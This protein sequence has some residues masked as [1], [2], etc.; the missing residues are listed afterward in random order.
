M[1]IYAKALQELDAH[2]HEVWMIGD[3]LE[4]EVLVPQQLG[5][6][7]VWVDYRGSGLPRQHAAWPFRVIRTFSDILTLL[8]REFPE[9][10][11]DRANAPNAE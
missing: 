5:I 4:W 9:M 1:R 8:A 10:M 11:A 3:N 7:G 6:Q 2:P